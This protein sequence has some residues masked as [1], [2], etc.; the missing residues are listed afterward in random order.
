[1]LRILIAAVL[2]SAPLAAQDSFGLSGSVP[3]DR[4]LTFL[5]S[6][7]FGPNSTSW[8]LACNLQTNA[9]S[10]LVVRLID[11]DGFA[12]S[13]QAQ[14]DS[15]NVATVS[16]Q[17]TAN[18]SLNGTYSGV[19]EFAV[20]IETENGS[21]ASDYS[22]NLVSN[23]GT[24]SFIREDQLLHSAAGFKATVQ[25]FAFWDGSVPAG[26]TLP[27]SMEL[28]FGPVQRTVFLRFEGAGSNLERI[29]LF[30][31]TGG[32]ATPMATFTNPGSGNVAAVPL[33]RSGTVF[34]RVNTRAVQAQSG[35]GSWAVSVPSGI[36]LRRVGTNDN[37]GG[38]SEEGCST[39]ES[40]GHLWLL[41]LVGAL[42]WLVRPRLKRHA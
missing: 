8:T 24:I 39:G 6:I 34:L 1:M 19:R 30:N 29:E 10:G 22:G 2:F 23:A 18:A 33:T 38:S 15:I 17:G 36:D 3:A 12:A 16:G 28:D 20:E 42:A 9:A 13:A 41:A 31:T 25:R 37:G 35:S 11:V 40:S 5:Y 4:R 26:S 32:T 21:T 14:P 7:D 27:V